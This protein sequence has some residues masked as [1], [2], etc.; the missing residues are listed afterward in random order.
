M[1][2]KEAHF[3]CMIA[4]ATTTTCRACLVTSFYLLFL[5]FARPFSHITFCVT[6]S[7]TFLCIL[8][9]CPPSFYLS[10]LLS[11]KE[12]SNKEASNHTLR[13]GGPP[14]IP[15]SPSKVN[16]CVTALCLHAGVTKNTKV[17][18]RLF[19]YLFEKLSHIH[20]NAKTY[21]YFK[22]YFFLCPS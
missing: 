9:L 17:R 2:G 4:V 22:L 3:S 16:T 20:T 19:F 18:L 13:P 10:H 1:E 11:D 6:F 15:K 5:T 14:P 7:V 12:A 21:L 8:F